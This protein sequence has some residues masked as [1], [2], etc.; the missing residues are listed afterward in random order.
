MGGVS[1]SH[2]TNYSSGPSKFTN[3]GE[4]FYNGRNMTQP[5]AKKAAAWLADNPESTFPQKFKG[6]S[7]NDSNAT[8]AHFS[9]GSPTG[10]PSKFGDYE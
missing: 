5:I 4:Y 9:I 3:T 10:R 6:A 7:K 1:S 8:P 2:N